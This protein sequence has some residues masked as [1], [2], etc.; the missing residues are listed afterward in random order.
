MKSND[1]LKN[2][3]FPLPKDIIEGIKVALS[4]FKESKNKSGLKRAQFLVNDGKIS[5]KE[6]ERL[7]NFFSN[8]NGEDEQEYR[9]SG[10]DLMKE[11]V[12]NGVN[13]LRAALDNVKRARM[14]AGE[15]NQYKQSH[16]KDRDNANPTNVN[17][18]NVQTS[19]DEIMDNRTTYS[20]SFKK[21]IDSITYL[22][23]YMDNNKN[24]I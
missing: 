23:E 19:S 4:T 7:K 17:T 18:A 5:F 15:E 16:T 3:S 20:E 6:M 14:K 21:E 22:I 8:Y 1:I 12:I 2:K 10:G 11:F 13:E 24:I 9:L